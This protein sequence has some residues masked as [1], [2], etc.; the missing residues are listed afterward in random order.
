MITINAT[1]AR[2]QWSS[3]LSQIKYKRQIIAIKRNKKTEA[4]LI[5]N[6]EYNTDL[7]DISEINAASSSFDF[8]HN[9]PEI[10]SI[11]DL[12]KSYV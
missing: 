4:L 10:Y 9:E 3:L 6:P 1:Q 11:Q 7:E 5:P 12:K 2:N 8:L